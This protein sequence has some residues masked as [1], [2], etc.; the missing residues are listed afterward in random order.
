MSQVLIIKQEVVDELRRNNFVFGMNSFVLGSNFEHLMMTWWFKGNNII[1]VASLGDFVQTVTSR[2]FEIIV[3]DIMSSKEFSN[4][5]HT[6][7]EASCKELQEIDD[8]FQEVLMNSQDEQATYKSMYSSMS[9]AF[10][11]LLS[12]KFAQVGIFS[13]ENGSVSEGSLVLYSGSP[14]VITGVAQQH[15][16]IK[17]LFN[18]HDL[19]VHQQQVIALSDDFG[20][21]DLHDFVSAMAPLIAFNHVQENLRKTGL[22]LSREN[23]DE[24]ILDN[25]CDRITASRD[26]SGGV[27]FYYPGTD[28]GVCIDLDGSECTVHLCK[29]HEFSTNVRVTTVDEF[30]TAEKY[31]LFEYSL[32]ESLLENCSALLKKDH[33][34]FGYLVTLYKVLESMKNTAKPT[35]SNE[36]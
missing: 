9:S 35:L 24:I 12:D 2:D 26:R 8:I 6:V 4:K 19:T 1:K 18:D 33:I 23:F 17:C 7:L 28:V 13:V 31:L 30:I 3:E 10:R 29:G 22:E 21:N 34:V 15:I 27:Y 5:F 20:K 14:Y 36:C 16:A 25:Q 32:V 11:Y